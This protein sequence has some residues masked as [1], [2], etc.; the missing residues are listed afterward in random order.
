[1]DSS[2][3]DGY[4]DVMSGDEEGIVVKNQWTAGEKTTSTV[5]GVS[6]SSTVAPRVDHY[7]HNIS[8]MIDNI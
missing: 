6:N 4:E 7:I 8:E 1:M 2:E 5:A 3:S